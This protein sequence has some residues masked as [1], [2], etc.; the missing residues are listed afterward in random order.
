MRYNKIKEGIFLSRPNRFIAM[1]LV[2][3][4]EEVCHVK[5]TG[6]CKELLHQGV[7]VILEESDNPSRKTRYDLI[8]VYKGK[9]LINIDS[10]A[11][12]KVFH[13]W[14]KDS[15]FFEDIKFIKPESKYGNSR[16]DFYVKTESREMFIEVKG[17]TLENDGV[18]LFPDAPTERG[19]KHIKELIDARKNGYEAYLFFIIQM[20]NC[21]YFIPNRETHREFA[22]ALELAEKSGVKVFALNCEVGED[23]MKISD[24][25]EVM[26]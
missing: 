21:K 24:F 6:R 4:K 7:R 13:E 9:E 16:F 1:V 25:V 10:M 18:V 11:P 20:K 22:E 14:L 8:A 17:V 23:N 5:N 2:E 3:G 19:V 15:N 12:N 26:I